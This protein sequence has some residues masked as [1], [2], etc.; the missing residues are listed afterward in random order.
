MWVLS[1]KRTKGKATKWSH[2]GFLNE[3]WSISLNSYSRTQWYAL[4]PRKFLILTKLGP[5]GVYTHPSNHNMK[6]PPLGHHEAHCLKV[7]LNSRKMR[8]LQF[9]GLEVCNN[10]IKLRER[11]ILNLHDVLWSY[12]PTSTAN[13]AHQGW[14]GCA[15]WLVAQRRNVIGFQTNVFLN[16]YGMS[17]H[18][19]AIFSLEV[20]TL[21]D[22]SWAH[23][24]INLCKI[25]Q[26]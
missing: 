22:S 9:H 19:V 11:K 13:S 23:C 21:L 3:N 18:A 8:P 17:F 12:Q 24:D 1:V 15:G 25:V 26:K 5:G 16:P 6:W 10:C 7:I 2:H 20:T 14:I 4:S